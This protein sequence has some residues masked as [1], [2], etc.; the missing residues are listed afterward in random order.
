MIRTGPI[1]SPLLDGPIA[2]KIRSSRI[3]LDAVVPSV[4]M[5][6]AYVRSGPPV[7]FDMSGYDYPDVVNRQ[8]VTA[9]YG[10]Y[11]GTWPY[12]I[13]SL[14][15]GQ[16][17]VPDRRSCGTGIFTQ[18]IVGFESP[19]PYPWGGTTNEKCT[20]YG[21]TWGV[22][23]RYAPGVLVNDV[24]YGSGYYYLPDHTAVTDAELREYLLPIEPASYEEINCAPG[25]SFEFTPETPGTTLTYPW[26]EVALVQ[27]W[28]G[29]R[30]ADFD[31]Y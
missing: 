15:L 31:W 27:F 17:K 7:D 24:Q 14:G 5:A 9:T 3:N 19:S 13:V 29:M 18:R 16:W 8:L 30:P 12:S 23:A 26:S 28:P 22:L 20:I 10:F 6:S 25:D 21:P 4:V 1:S 11:P 2:S